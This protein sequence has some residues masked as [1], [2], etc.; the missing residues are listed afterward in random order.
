MQSLT[1]AAVKD[2]AAMKQ[3]AYL[4]MIFLPASFLAV[5]ILHMMLDADFDIP[6]DG[7]RDE[8]S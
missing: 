5:S 4:T 8:C 2:S 1:Q 6:V 3:I 7:F